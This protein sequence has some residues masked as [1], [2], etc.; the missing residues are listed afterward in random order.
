MKPGTS[1]DK[2]EPAFPILHEIDP[3]LCAPCAY[4]KYKPLYLNVEALHWFDECFIRCIC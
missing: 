3:F 2:D 4:A 1:S